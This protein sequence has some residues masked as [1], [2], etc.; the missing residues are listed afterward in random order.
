MLA[1]RVRQFHM[2]HVIESG[3]DG[4]IPGMGF[5]RAFLRFRGISGGNNK[6]PGVIHIVLGIGEI[7]WNLHGESR[8]IVRA[9]FLRNGVVLLYRHLPL[10]WRLGRQA[11]LRHTDARGTWHVRLK[12]HEGLIPFHRH[13]ILNSDCMPYV[14]QYKL[15]PGARRIYHNIGIAIVVRDS[16]FRRRIQFGLDDSV[17]MNRLSELIT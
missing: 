5:R 10:R 17:K 7:P 13:R 3:H 12:S 8:S 14:L 4:A 1:I 9:G 2:T 16:I 11:I 15:H 6:T